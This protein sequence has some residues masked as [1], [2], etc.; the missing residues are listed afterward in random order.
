MVEWTGNS[1]SKYWRASV[2]PIRYVSLFVNVWKLPDSLLLWMTLIRA[3]SNSNGVCDK[4]ILYRSIYSFW[5][6]K[7]FP[8]Y[9]MLILRVGG[10]EKFYHPRCPLI[11]H[12]FYADKCWFSWMEIINPLSIFWRLLRFMK[13]GLGRLSIKQNQLYTFCLKLTRPEGEVFFV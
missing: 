6:K 1:W 5:W 8:S 2:S 10:L 13:V 3:S 12:L 11:S 4:G 9:Y 7:F